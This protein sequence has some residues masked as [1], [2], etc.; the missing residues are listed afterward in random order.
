M[1]IFKHIARIVIA[2]AALLPGLGAA[3][4]TAE[5]PERYFP[6]PVVPDSISTLQGRTDFLMEHFWDFC[7]MS[8]AFSSRS[9]MAGALTD[10]FS[11]VQYASRD[12]ALA[13]IDKLLGQLRKRPSELLFVVEQAE[14][15]L[16]SDTAQYHSE[17]A[18]KPFL[19][20][21][22]AN[23]KVQPADKARYQR[24][25]NLIE[26]SGIGTLPPDMPYTAPDGSQRSL[27][28]D[29][30]EVTVVMVI[31]P[32][33]VDCRIAKVKLDANQRISELVGAG[34]VRIVA[35]YP[36]E[37]DQ[38]WLDY[39]ATLPAG[40]V[41]GAAPEIYDYYDVQ[42]TPDIYV[43]DESHRLLLRHTVPDMLVEILS[44]L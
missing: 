2:V 9:K 12:K 16:Y 18:Y 8:K 29:T 36:D 30:A 35:L 43:Y 20:A 28:A 4:Q 17:E 7:D 5:M 25:L 44:R 11:F 32:D 42:S 38:A 26:R 3:A 19:E 23:K 24:H 40:W 10:Y 15:N 31:D 41:A 21:L 1:K 33:C 13:S 22:I 14:A 27:A 34:I 6:Y 39:A 37:P